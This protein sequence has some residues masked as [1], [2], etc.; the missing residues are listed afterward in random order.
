VLPAD[1]SQ[2]CQQDAAQPAALELVDHRHRHLC[3]VGARG[4]VVA[5]D[6]DDSFRA[7]RSVGG[8]D[9]REPVVVV[10]DSEAVRER[11]GH[12]LDRREEPEVNGALGHRGH[13]L[14]EEH[15]VLGNDGAQVHLRALTELQGA[16]LKTGRSHHH[17]R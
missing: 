6:A 7:G 4:A 15:F 1:A 14:V 11:V 3:H 8:G 2:A 13:R 9:Q 17:T 5:R 12:P 16:R 10:D